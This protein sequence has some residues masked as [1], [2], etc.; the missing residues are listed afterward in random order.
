MLAGVLTGW[1]WHITTLNL[2]WKM[3][4]LERLINEV[5]NNM[6]TITF[7]TMPNRTVKHM[8]PRREWRSTTPFKRCNLELWCTSL[9]FFQVLWSWSTAEDLSSGWP[10]LFRLPTQEICSCVYKS[11][12]EVISEAEHISPLSANRDVEHVHRKWKLDFVRFHKRTFSKW[13]KQKNLQ[14]RC[15]LFGCL[16]LKQLLQYFYCRSTRILCS[17]KLELEFECILG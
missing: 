8:P 15:C 14:H 5:L 9:A 1:E 12:A 16:C 7:F 10:R 13:F 4:H 11:S 3:L 6:S 17:G 2:E